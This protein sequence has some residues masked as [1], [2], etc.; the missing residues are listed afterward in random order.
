M[1]LAVRFF[2]SLSRR[3]GKVNVVSL[4]VCGKENVFVIK[5]NYRKRA[6][7]I[8]L[9]ITDICSDYC[10]QLHLCDQN[11][12]RWRNLLVA[13]VFFIALA[14]IRLY[15]RVPGS[16]V[17]WLRCCVFMCVNKACIRINVS[18]FTFFQSC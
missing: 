10:D 1:G 15:L 9:A 12:R 11:G 16:K 8:R 13:A 6:V 17:D 5:C 7:I 2:W 3:K 18:G 14:H 4:R